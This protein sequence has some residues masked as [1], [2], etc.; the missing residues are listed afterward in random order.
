MP[1]MKA[2]E[3]TVLGVI[4]GLDK[5]FIIPPFQRNYEWGFE[6]CDELFSDIIN[7]SLSHKPH[8]LG[9][10]VYY[11][12]KNNS[13]SYGEYI[14]VDGQQRV[15]TILLLLCAIRDTSQDENL[16]RKINNRF[17]INDTTDE[18]FRIRLKQTSHDSNPFIAIVDNT[19]RNNDY[20]DSNLVKNYKHFIELILSSE[21]NPINIFEAMPILEVVDV[22]LNVNDLSSVQTVFE[23][24]NA[25]GKKLTPADLIRNYLLLS[26]SAEEQESLYKRY[27]VRIEDNVTNNYISKFAHDYLVM[28]VYDD[29]SEENIYKQFKAHFENSQATHSDILIEMNVD[30][31]VAVIDRL[32]YLDTQMIWCFLAEQRVFIS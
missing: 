17:L 11:P 12:G 27:W 32:P 1:K 28:N 8:Y 6:Q 22:N 4:G 30:Q 7:A 21:I 31:T 20:S 18:R 14:L 13:A 16:K 19:L 5:V 23:K 9:N 15:T 26:D 3:Q 10:V 2:V 29:V 24:I 25:T